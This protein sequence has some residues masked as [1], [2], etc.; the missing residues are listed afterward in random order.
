[1]KNVKFILLTLVFL[2]ALFT[3]FS[4]AKKKANKD[5]EQFRYD[6]SCAGVGAQGT[7]LVKVWSY[8]KKSQP[9]VATEQSR[10]NAVHG[11]I[12]KGFSG[13]TQGCPA[14]RA[15]ASDPTIAQQH[16]DFFRK[17]FSDGGDYMKYVLST[18]R[19]DRVKVGR[20]YK[21]AC[22]VSVA[23]DQLRKD[24]EAA[25]ILKGISTGF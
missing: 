4:Q 5:T 24:L 18:E 16:S 10:K 13:A 12:F 17:F 19:V 15:L 6:I 25:G 1:M 11:I 21:I 9:Q 23:K 2:C 20:E 14:Q 8:C 7:Y 3:G 22:V